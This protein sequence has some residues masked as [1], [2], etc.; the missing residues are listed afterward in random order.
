MFF[1]KT[2]HTPKYLFSS[3][4]ENHKF[5]FVR[6]VVVQLF[7]KNKKVIIALSPWR[8]APLHEYAIICEGTVIFTVNMLYVTDFD[9]CPSH[10][11]CKFQSY[12]K[13]LSD[14]EHLKL[15]KASPKSKSS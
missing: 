9:L 7:I 2:L 8:V 5:Y 12:T 11:S 13:P 15:R 6:G 4:F 10:T 3:I 1:R 14:T